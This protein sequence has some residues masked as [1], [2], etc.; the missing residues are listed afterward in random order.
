LLREAP[1]SVLA[2][3]DLPR[4]DLGID[5]IARPRSGMYWAI[6]AKF[7]SDEKVRSAGAT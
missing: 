6:Q 3:I 1:E 2:E 7:R 5:L 4:N